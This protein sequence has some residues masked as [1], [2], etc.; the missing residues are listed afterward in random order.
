MNVANETMMIF[1]FGS[2]VCALKPL[3]GFILIG[4]CF[5]WSDVHKDLNRSIVI[6]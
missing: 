4:S 5:G 2:H 6:L 3:S 1:N